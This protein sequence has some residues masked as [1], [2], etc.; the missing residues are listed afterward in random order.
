[1]RLLPLAAGP[2]A[3][4][5]DPSVAVRVQHQVS[6]QMP[7][8]ESLLCPPIVTGYLDLLLA[9]SQDLSHAGT[10]LSIL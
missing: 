6:S 9:S 8:S 7:F 10:K 1:M 2:V 3:S 4:P 5:L